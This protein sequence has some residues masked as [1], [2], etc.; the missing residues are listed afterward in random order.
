M[1]GFLNGKRVEKIFTK[2]RTS[3]K[4]KIV[5]ANFRKTVGSGSKLVVG[6]LF[7]HFIAYAKIYGKAAQKLI[8]FGILLV[9]KMIAWRHLSQPLSISH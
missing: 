5:H 7:L 1:T 8:V 6:V 2:D 4:I 3:A 9:L